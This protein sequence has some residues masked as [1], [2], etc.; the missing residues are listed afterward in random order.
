M[1]RYSTC[2][3]HLT[4]Q[5]ADRYNG[6]EF[7]IRYQSENDRARR[8][9]EMSI[10]LH[11]FPRL[12]FPAE[13]ADVLIRRITARCWDDLVDYLRVKYPAGNRI[14]SIAYWDAPGGRRNGLSA[15]S[16]H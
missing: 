4:K 1:W 5:T 2:S 13:F 6:A 16:F 9:K 14:R 3:L 12:K 11:R 8:Q 7:A 15:D 10:L